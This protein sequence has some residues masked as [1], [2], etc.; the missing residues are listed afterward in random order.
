VGA[1]FATYVRGDD[2]LLHDMLAALR[3]HHMPVLP[4]DLHLTD[5][6]FA[7]AVEFAPRTRP[8]RFTILE[9]KNMD[10]AQSVQRVSEFVQLVETS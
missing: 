3:R 5:Q 1:L 9:H 4:V 7:E 8:D 2:Q 10:L 6:E